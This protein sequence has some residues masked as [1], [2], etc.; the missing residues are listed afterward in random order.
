MIRDTTMCQGLSNRRT[1]QW[2]ST[3]LIV[4]VLVRSLIPPGFMPGRSDW[5]MLCP[6]GLPEQLLAHHA[7]HSHHQDPHHGSRTHVEHCPFAGLAGG[8]VAT[9]LPLVVM[10]APES[11]LSIQY[12][13]LAYRTQRVRL[14]PARGPPHLA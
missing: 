2:L 6:E 4:A 13:R 10:D 3:V 1:H 7:A 12:V 11:Q 8:P 5:L 14:P 9:C